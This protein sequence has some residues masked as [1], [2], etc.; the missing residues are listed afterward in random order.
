[1]AFF[2]LEEDRVGDKQISRPVSNY[3]FSALEGEG[4]VELAM[5]N[6]YCLF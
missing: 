1:L 2:S 4:L 6:G 5:H 3:R